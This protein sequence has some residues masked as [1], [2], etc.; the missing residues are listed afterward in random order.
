[1]LQ[2]KSLIHHLITSSMVMSSAHK[3]Q[4]ESLSSVTCG[5]DLDY[6]DTGKCTFV[7]TRSFFFAFIKL[8]I[9]MYIFAKI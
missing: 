3:M 8:T 2:F 6:I 1:M 4:W 5:V 9:T 7:V